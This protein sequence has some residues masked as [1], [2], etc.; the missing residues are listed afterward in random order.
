MTPIRDWRGPK[1]DA[2]EFAEFDADVTVTLYEFGVTVEVV[3]LC[4]YGQPV[5]EVLFFWDYPEL[6][7]LQSAGGLI[8]SQCR[9]IVNGL[10]DEVLS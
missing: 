3:P 1:L 9:H 2:I 8:W 6:S 7:E 4:R 10:V 5:R